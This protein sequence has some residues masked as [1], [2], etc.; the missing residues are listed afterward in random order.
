MIT[1]TAFL[2]I[3]SCERLITILIDQD[4][5]LMR[6]YFP[7]LSFDVTGRAEVVGH[8][9]ALHLDDEYGTATYLRLTE[10]WCVGLALSVADALAHEDDTFGPE[11]ALLA[12][13]GAGLLR[14]SP[15]LLERLASAA[16]GSGQTSSR[17][18]S[19]KPR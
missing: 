6:G 9:A 13:F 2:T 7:D 12:T 11:V 16:A 19:P 14:S 5:G 17:P 4:S 1:K 8:V 10:V 15:A 3:H 18:L